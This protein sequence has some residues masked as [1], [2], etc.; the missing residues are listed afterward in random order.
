[1]DS[2]RAVMSFVF[3]C[4]CAA[5]CS[6]ADRHTVIPRLDPVTGN[7]NFGSPRLSDIE[8]QLDAIIIPEVNFRG[9]NIHDV[10]EFLDQAIT[11]YEAS[12]DASGFTR[13]RIA[14]DVERNPRTWPVITFRGK[15][16]T[17]L[18]VLRLTVAL[19]GLVYH[20]DDRTITISRQ[21]KTSRTSPS[22][23]GE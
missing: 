15:D 18:R 8:K 11:Q 2:V 13:A 23:D 21:P 1:M 6:T 10:A 19:G 20:A 12:G 3:V 5:S 17:V 22:R 9:A 14:C 7:V 16:M 4:L